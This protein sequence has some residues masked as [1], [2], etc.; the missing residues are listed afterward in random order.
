MAGKTAMKKVV[1]TELRK[2]IA[3]LRR[4]CTFDYDTVQVNARMV[5]DI[6]DALEAHLVADPWRGKR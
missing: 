3:R 2:A 4:I 1:T 5:S 6:C